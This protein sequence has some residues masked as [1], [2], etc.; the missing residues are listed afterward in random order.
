MRIGF[1]GALT[2]LMLGSA[3]ANMPVARA[4]DPPSASIKPIDPETID[5]G[6]ALEKAR[7]LRKLSDAGNADATYEFGRLLAFFGAFGPRADREHASEWRELQG[8]HRINYWLELA[9]E[10]GNPRAIDA[11]CRMGNDPLAPA[12]LREQGNVRCKELRQKHPAK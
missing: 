4:D 11:V 6:A 8:P 12:D 1:R 2:A 5:P 10:Q 9:A 3:L 7:E